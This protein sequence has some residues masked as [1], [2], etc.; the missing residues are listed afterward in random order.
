MSKN[1]DNSLSGLLRRTIGDRLAPEADDFLAMCAEDIVWEFPFAPAGGVHRIEGKDAVAA[2]LPKVGGLINVS[3]GSLTAV[4]RTTDPDTTIIEF[5][6]TG[7]GAATGL[8]YDQRYICVFRTRDGRI[9]HFKDYWN[10]I[11]LLS[12]VGGEQALAAALGGFAQ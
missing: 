8:P 12:A 4:H 2:Y 7:S 11:T 3:G 6:I 10:P 9:V 5:E 1:P